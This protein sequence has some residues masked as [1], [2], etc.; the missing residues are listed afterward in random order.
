MRLSL[1][2]FTVCFLFLISFLRIGFAPLKNFLSPT[3]LKDLPFIPTRGRSLAV[4]AEL[5]TL[6]LL[7]P[8]YAGTKPMRPT[9]KP[10]NSTDTDCF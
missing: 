1:C 2:C 9:C 10:N 4:Q 3:I 6:L 5:R 7:L 8:S